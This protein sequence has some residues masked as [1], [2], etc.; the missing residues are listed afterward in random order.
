MTNSKLPTVPFLMLLLKPLADHLVD[1]SRLA[2]ANTPYLGFPLI[3]KGE[4]EVIRD[5]PSEKRA[6]TCSRPQ[7]GET[8]PPPDIT[9]MFRALNIGLS[10]P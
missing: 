4:K 6:G 7:T 2:F 8:C 5:N 10:P 1:G 9:V 3:F